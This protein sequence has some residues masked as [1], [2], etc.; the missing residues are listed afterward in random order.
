MDLADSLTVAARMSLILVYGLLFVRLVLYHKTIPVEGSVE[1]VKAWNWW[2]KATI[3]M[4]VCVGAV[5][6]PSSIALAVGSINVVEFEW[7]ALLGHIIN[8]YAGVCY[9]VGL[10]VAHKR[11]HGGV[12]YYGA[13]LPVAT[14]YVLADAGWI[15]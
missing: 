3:L 11:P 6:S 9:L 14:A 2:L 15:I 5:Y 4:A 1:R 8:F 7:V 10:D 13:I 12:F